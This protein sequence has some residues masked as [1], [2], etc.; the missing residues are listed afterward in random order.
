MAF[1]LLIVLGFIASIYL[2]LFPSQKDK[3]EQLMSVYELRADNVS[4]PKDTQ[5]V[6]LDSEGESIIFHHIAYSSAETFATK[7]SLLE[8]AAYTTASGSN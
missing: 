4:P 7:P 8:Y 5:V 1:S 3:N 2:N 6:D